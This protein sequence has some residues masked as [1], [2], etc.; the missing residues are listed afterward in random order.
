[1]AA[2][3]RAMLVMFGMPCVVSGDRR[4]DIPETAP[5]YLG[6]F[7]AA[8]SGW[9]ARETVAAYLWPE[10]PTERAQHNLRVA[11]NRLG[12]LLR[13]WGLAD[14]LQAERRRLRLTVAS[15]LGDFRDAMASGDW[16]RA[17]ALP[18]G[19]LLDGLQC[20]P[21]PALAEWLSVEREA[22]RRAWRKAL[23]EAAQ[24]GAAIDDALSRYVA[25]FA[26]DGEAVTLLAARMAAAGRSLE[27][28]EV[29]AA[30]RRAA[31]DEL[32][33][34]ELQGY[35][36]R[37]GETAAA[38]VPAA[39][40]AGADALLGRDTE[41]AALDALLKAHRWLT[42][43][44]LPGSGKSSLVRRW[45]ADQPPSHLGP[46]WVR[47]DLNER[48]TAASVALALVAKL[49]VQPGPRRHATGPLQ[50]LPLLEGLV[51][52][53]GL[54][55]GNM[56]DGLSMLLHTLASDSPKLRVLAVARGPLGVAG[57]RVHRLKGLS[58]Q[59]G[60]EGEPS[61]AAQL[62]VREAQR[63]RPHAL[64]PDIGNEAERIARL[65]EGLPLAL[66]L[67]ASWC[68]WLEPQAMAAVLER[69]VRNAAGTFD[70]T[71]HTWL[72]APWDRLTASQQR[73]LGSLSLFPRAFD[74]ATAV[75][76]TAASPADIEGL[77]SQCLLEVEEEPAP[78][79]R[80][81]ALVREFA[82]ARMNASPALRRESIGRYLGA[83]DALL[84]PR[85]VEAGHPVFGAAQ[86][87]LCIDEV[88]S[89]W[90]LALETGAL[91]HMQ[92]LSAA[93]LAWHDA[94][95]EYATGAR[96][97]ALALEA[98]D[99]TVAPEAAV[100]ARVQ[101]ARATLS[102]RASD[103]DAATTLAQ[104]TCRLG[105]STGQRRTVRMGLNI[106]GLSHWMALRLDDARAA[107]A[108]GLASAIE[109]GERRGESIFSSNLALV[110]KSRGDYTAA[111]AI[112]RRS[113]E[114]GRATSDWL[115]LCSHLNNLA[116]LLRQTRRFEECEALAQECL[117]LT[118]EHAL[119]GER[120]FA[121][122]GLA[123]LQHETGHPDRAEQYLVLIDDCDAD[124]IEGPVRAGAAQLRAQMALDRGDGEAAL[125]QLARALE[126]SVGN[127]DAA[128]RAEAL[129]L[130]GEWLARHDGRP[131]EALR[132]WSALSHTPSIHAS[133]KDELA[134]RLG[135]MG[136]GLE[137][138]P[139]ERADLGL[140][141]EQ[142][143]ATARQRRPQAAG[144]R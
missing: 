10:A 25:A 13:A 114:L 2:G 126:I 106:L 79:L 38:L 20:T 113:I 45:L 42:L 139:A 51:V 40:A 26:S 52:L 33:A 120:P 138:G 66:K 30:F 78:Q 16:A 31:S 94:Q 116:N 1:M 96:H 85:P 134:K 48:S 99:E 86:V 65:C 121:L 49:G 102:Y 8:Q 142:A 59:R 140:A 54:D 68:R 123:L 11:I 53:D 67:A 115:R 56:A 60:A 76:A 12:V 90:P 23:V 141:V 100:L 82:G 39:P 144:A 84:G 73:I 28:R 130:Y 136:Q 75:A 93:L 14:A 18:G 44:G 46:R 57:E 55:P 62:L 50:Q 105:H 35:L 71:L 83:V 15:D 131:N 124:S 118:H 4:H 107:F 9:T 133:L 143:L 34:D 63:M 77:Q 101:A 58:V 81:H 111:E 87:S 64:W 19:P 37:M 98:L 92:V 6:L 103:Y 122:V 91:D 127:D 41:L 135:G 22:L 108:Q 7:L 89:A 5:A 32:S 24:I 43:A 29:I 117:R 97:L 129:M 80:L 128:N 27:A 17:G 21:Y 125:Q 47:V 132:L 70:D 95:G 61:E 88:M 36:R 137:L 74:M 104:E 109:D 3:S 110:E 69:S 119:D 112:W 72:A